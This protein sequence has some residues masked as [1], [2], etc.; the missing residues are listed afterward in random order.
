MQA[1]ARIKAAIFDFGGV[2][3]FPPSEIQWRE[4]A[5]FCG[6]DRKAFEAAFWKDRDVYDAGE[7]P[8]WY[9]EKV[10]QRLG[11]RFDSARIDAMVAR[12][13]AFWS[14]FDD[15]VLGYARE[16]RG[17]G[18]RTGILSNLPRPIGEKLKSLPGFLTHFD[19]VTFSYEHGVVKPR[20]AIYESAIHGLNV[21]P[22]EALF[23]DDRST[24]VEGA[25][26]VGLQAHLYSTW[27][28]FVANR[29]AFEFPPEPRR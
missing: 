16:L 29:Q 6:A 26:A 28:H 19:E 17:E 15:R 14:R 12:E 3:C 11:L 22:G 5:E 18:I 2:I 20:A 27:E 4:A 25:R 8:R 9:W 13:I 1:G 10:A 21:E 24:N 23:I 7:S